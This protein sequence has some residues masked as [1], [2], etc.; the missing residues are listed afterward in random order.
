MTGVDDDLAVLLAGVAI[1]ASLLP[2]AVNA[3]FFWALAIVLAI[4]TD[5]DLYSSVVIVL[6][7]GKVLILYSLLYFAS[8]GHMNTDKLHFCFKGAQA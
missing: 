7:T 3:G 5:R 6:A 1:S 2:P 4:G 8:R